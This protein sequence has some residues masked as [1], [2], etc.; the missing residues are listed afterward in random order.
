MIE[1]I[2]P[3]RY[4][5]L[6]RVLERAEKNL[7][8]YHMKHQRPWVKNKRYFMALSEVPC[9]Y[10]DPYDPTDVDNQQLPC[11]HTGVKETQHPLP[12][13]FKKRLRVG[14]S[15]LWHFTAK[16]CPHTTIDDEVLCLAEYYNGK[17]FFGKHKVG[18]CPHKKV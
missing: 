10:Q 1:Q 7:Q 14:V 11:L 3:S 13:G 17:T 4:W 2:T 16:G 18:E 5:V 12:K 6:R 9:S 15:D 8:A